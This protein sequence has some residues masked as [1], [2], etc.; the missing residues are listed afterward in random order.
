MAK[1]P[2]CAYMVPS[3]LCPTSPPSGT[4][5]NVVSE[6]TTAAPTPRDVAEGLHGER[7]EVPEEEADAE[8]DGEQVGHEEPEWR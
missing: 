1:A 5:M 4:P 3:K 7:T 2:I 6:A 8:E